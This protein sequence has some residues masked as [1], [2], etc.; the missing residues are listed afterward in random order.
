MPYYNNK[1]LFLFRKC[2]IILKSNN[3]AINSLQKAELNR[4]VENLEIF[5]SISKK[6]T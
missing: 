6:L 2:T 3:E 4:K 5:E 1:K